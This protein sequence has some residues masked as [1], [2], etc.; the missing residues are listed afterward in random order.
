MDESFKNT[1]KSKKTVLKEKSES[2][3]KIETNEE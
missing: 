3:K 2:I 1:E